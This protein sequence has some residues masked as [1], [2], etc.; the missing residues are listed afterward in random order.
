MNDSTDLDRIR[1]AA[2]DRIDKARRWFRILIACTALVEGAFLIAFVL[3]ADWNDRLH[4]LVFLAAC[5]VYLTLGTAV[6]TL[7]GASRLTTVRDSC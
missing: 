4:V 5:L 3:L 2:L 6:I 7:G 1:G